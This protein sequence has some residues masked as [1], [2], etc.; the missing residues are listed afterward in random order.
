MGHL[1][2][3]LSLRAAAY[4]KA[5]QSAARIGFASWYRTNERPPLA[6]SQRMQ[7]NAFCASLDANLVQCAPVS[8]TFAQ[9]N[10]NTRAAAAAAAAARGEEL[11]ARGGNEGRR[12]NNES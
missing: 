4:L 5:A 7:A 1:A 3:R 9:K 2:G 11:N 12:G 8:E 10:G 6:V